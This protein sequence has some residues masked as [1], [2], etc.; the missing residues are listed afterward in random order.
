MKNQIDRKYHLF[1]AEGQTPGRLAGEIAI[2]LRGK[3]KRDFAPHID[4][5]DLAVVINADK[6]RITGN[7]A[8][9][10]VYFRF[11]GYPGGITA[12]TLKDQIAKDSRKVIQSAVWGML[13]KNK[14]RDRMMTRLLVYKD[15]KH[16]HK[17]Q[18]TH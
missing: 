2:V 10:K 1:N 11:S 14:L 12:T 16:P 15:D 7:K 5:G 17:I 4:G 8:E 3:N 9:G 18:I 13:P 6:I